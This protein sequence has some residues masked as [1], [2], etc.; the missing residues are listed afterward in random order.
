VTLVAILVIVVVFDGDRTAVTKLATDRRAI[1]TAGVAGLGL[2]GAAFWVLMARS[3]SSFLGIPQPDLTAI[4]AARQSWGKLPLRLEDLV[5]RFGWLDVSLPRAFTLTWGV[6]VVLL[7]LAGLCFG[8]AR[9]R[10]ALVAACVIVLAMPIAAE[11]Y[12]ASRYGFFWQGRYSLPFAVGVPL[13]AALAVANRRAIGRQVRIA[14]VTVGASIAAFGQLLAHVTAMRRYITGTDAPFLDY[15]STSTWRPPLP[16][17]SLLA[18]SILT[19]A[20]YAGWLALLA[21]RPA[22]VTERGRPAATLGPLCS[23]ACRSSSSTIGQPNT[24]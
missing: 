2:A 18:L 22:P 9:Q 20:A 5:G 11:A 1:L 21:T 4:D 23:P 12:R 17:W 19:A 16:S 15:L 6:A 10:V 24:R 13:L 3:F 8:R 14:T 7:L